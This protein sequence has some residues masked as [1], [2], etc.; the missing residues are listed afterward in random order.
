MGFSPIGSWAGAQRVL[1]PVSD[2]M[3]LDSDVGRARWKGKVV[4]K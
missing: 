3:P 1:H 4:E 2:G